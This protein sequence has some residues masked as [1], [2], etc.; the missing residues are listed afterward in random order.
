MAIFVYV[1]SSACCLSA[2]ADYNSIEIAY[3]WNAMHILLEKF[4][5]SDCRL[6]RTSALCGA[7]IEVYEFSK[8]EALTYLHLVSGVKHVRFSGSVRSDR[9]R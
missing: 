2:T 4:K 3:Y 6:V 9:A 1:C 5:F 8:I 7:E